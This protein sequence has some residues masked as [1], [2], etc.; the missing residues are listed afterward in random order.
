MTVPILPFERFLYPSANVAGGEQIANP[1]F[2]D[3]ITGWSAYNN[4]GG[5]PTI[6]FGSS[7]RRFLSGG[8]LRMVKNSDHL[9]VPNVNLSGALA[10]V[11]PPRGLILPALSAVGDG[12]NLVGPIDEI[13][14]AYG[15]TVSTQIT[16]ANGERWADQ[17]TGVL[18]D[19]RA[20]IR[21]EVSW[22][23]KSGNVLQ[24]VIG[25][26]RNEN[27]LNAQTFKA[28]EQL[29][30]T[31]ILRR[32]LFQA[33]VQTQ[34]TGF[35][36]DSGALTQA[37][38]RI[39]LRYTG[40]STGLTGASVARPFSELIPNAW[41]LLEVEMDA[42]EK[43]VDDPASPADEIEIRV[44]A[45]WDNHINTEVHVDDARV[46]HVLTL[47]D[48]VS[49]EPSAPIR[50]QGLAFARTAGGVLRGARIRPEVVSHNLRWDR[51]APLKH[52]LRHKLETWHRHLAYPANTMR[53]FDY[54]AVHH[55]EKDFRARQAEVVWA[56]GAPV[57]QEVE[58]GR[59]WTASVPLEYVDPET[60][61]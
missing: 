49:K 19:R 36:G 54:Q 45:H 38:L 50:D 48:R 22:N 33:W 12:Y 15:P 26:I 56:D 28:T 34:S 53:S 60:T 32:L 44:D 58:L 4:G 21:C 2:D 24:N 59:D 20:A 18:F 11:V 23:G 39:F 42:E 37:R 14:A 41:H 57:F 3:D 43:N 55:S 17:G 7:Q 46:Y 51:R 6:S 35:G 13:T 61:L 16:V 25:Y 9:G 40:G 27:N 10:R 31:S 52:E 1:T 30:G 29:I 47:S 5:Q 8:Y